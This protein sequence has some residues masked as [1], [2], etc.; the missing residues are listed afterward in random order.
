MAVSG[1]N[2]T[3]ETVPLMSKIVDP[4]DSL[5]AERG[6]CQKSPR[7]RRSARLTEELKYNAIFFVI[8]LN[9]R[10]VIVVVKSFVGV[11]AD[12]RLRLDRRL[13]SKFLEANL[14]ASSLALL[15]IYGDQ[16]ID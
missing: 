11:D 14:A 15:L 3:C 6:H 5:R 9:S 8:S 10:F 7:M 12:V 13:E 2:T 16:E 4:D 1:N